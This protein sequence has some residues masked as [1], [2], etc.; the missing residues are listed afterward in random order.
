MDDMKLAFVEESFVY[1][2][3]R[4]RRNLLA[5]CAGFAEQASHAGKR[6]ASCT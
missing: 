4:P 5:T 2:Y 6:N 1:D 3:L